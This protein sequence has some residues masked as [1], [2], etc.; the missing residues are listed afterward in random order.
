M[1]WLTV[2]PIRAP[3]ERSAGCAAARTVHPLPDS[4]CACPRPLAWNSRPERS[5]VSTGL[6]LSFGAGAFESW[7]SALMGTSPVAGCNGGGLRNQIASA[8]GGAEQAVD[9]SSST[10]SSSSGRGASASGG[11][12][13]SPPALCSSLSLPTSATLPERR[14]G[15]RSLRHPERRLRSG[16]MPYR[17]VRHFGGRSARLFCDRDGRQCACTASGVHARSQSKAS[18]TR[19]ALPSSIRL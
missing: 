12:A 4:K 17:Y 11:P 10:G 13:L 9:L 16:D 18:S 14:D 7:R 8:D 3:R 1:P 19:Q 2:G 5:T 15:L 6:R